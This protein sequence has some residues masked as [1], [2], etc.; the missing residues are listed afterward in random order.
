MNIFFQ[1]IALIF[2]L[3]FFSLC[4]SFH[5]TVLHA[6]EETLAGRVVVVRGDVAALNSAGARALARGGEIFVG[7]TITT[8]PDGFAQIRLEDSAIVALKADT[9]FE[10]IEYV[11]N[12]EATQTE[13]ATLNL[14]QGGFRT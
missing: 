10:I 9:A 2:N 5:T 11:F 6:A 3:A 14:I 4:L 8:G 12:P 13:R 1:R 7:D